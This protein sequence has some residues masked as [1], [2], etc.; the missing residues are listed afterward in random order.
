MLFRLTARLL[1]RLLLRLTV[2]GVENVPRSGA[3]LVSDAQG[4]LLPKEFSIS[5]ATWTAQSDERF[6]LTARQAEDLVVE[7]KNL[8]IDVAAEGVQELAEAERQAVAVARDD[9]HVQIG[10]H[11]LEARGHRRCAT[12]D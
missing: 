5:H 1:S 9:P 11:G 6:P 7:K 2:R 3:L 10:P 12:V 4:Q 8:Q